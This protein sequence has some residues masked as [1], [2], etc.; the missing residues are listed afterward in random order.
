MVFRFLVS[1]ST[2]TTIDGRGT[3]KEAKVHKFI[4]H[5]PWRKPWV[6]VRV[7]KLDPGLSESNKRQL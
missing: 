7:E 1:V 5:S 3:K 2:T 4:E 6:W